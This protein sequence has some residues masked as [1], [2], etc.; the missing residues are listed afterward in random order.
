MVD[1]L[2]DISSS[3]REQSAASS[4]IAKNIER[5]AQMSEESAQA[6]QHTTD[7]AHHLQELSAALRT[8]R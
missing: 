6:V 1:V 3:I 7:A 4:D 2:N 8:P 5:I